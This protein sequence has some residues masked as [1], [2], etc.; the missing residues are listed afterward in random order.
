MKD[1]YR[2]HE[3]YNGNIIEYRKSK[4]EKILKVIKPICEVFEISSYDYIYD[5]HRER[6]VIEGQAIGCS[7]NSIGAVV[8]ELINYIWIET[9]AHNRCLGA[10]EKQTLNY[11][12]RMWI[13]ENV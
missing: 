3:G 10:F 12:K 9:Y 1:F 6:L 11:L 2:E 13:K 7:G 4:R 5:E 8:M